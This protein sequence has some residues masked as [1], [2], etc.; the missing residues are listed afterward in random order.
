MLK[1]IEKKIEYWDQYLV[2]DLIETGIFE[3]NET[4][5]HLDKLHKDRQ[6]LISQ[7][8]KGSMIR[9]RKNW[10]KDGEK[11]TAYFLRLE[12]YN[13]KRK[14]R[15][16]L[17]VGNKIITDNKNI[18]KAQ[19]DFYEDLYKSREVTLPADFFEGLT[20]PK[21][22]EIDKEMLESTNSR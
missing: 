22:S 8:L 6:D 16:Q 10:L 20:I 2:N 17:R 11:N 15:F 19:D 5:V 9:T 7:K 14:N 3:R 1:A 13:Y 21:V 4:Q 12:S 18:L